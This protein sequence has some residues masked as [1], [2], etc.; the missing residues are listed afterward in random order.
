MA[1]EGRGARARRTWPQRGLI[2]FNVVV[3]MA[4]LGTAF[5]LAYANDK[6]GQV[7]TVDIGGGVLEDEP[8]DPGDPQNYLIVGTDSAA[9]LDP[10]DPAARVDEGV[11]SDTIMVLR[12]DPDQTQAQLLSFPRDLYVNIPD[13]GE[14]KINAA[15]SAGR[16]SL[17]ATITQTFGIPINHYVEVDFRGFQELVEA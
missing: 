1:R 8:E 13:Y 14:A 2:T 7:E 4:T 3:V 6:L 10:D 16:E 5:A 17:I 11:L 15:L 12:V 9:G